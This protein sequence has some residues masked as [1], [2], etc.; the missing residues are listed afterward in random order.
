MK[1]AIFGASGKTGVRLVEEGLRRDWEIVGACRDL[2]ADKLSDFIREPRFTLRTAPLI[3]DEHF[4]TQTLKGCDAAVSIMLSV[5][6]LMCTDLVRSLE[7]ASQAN[8]VKRFIFTAGEVTARPDPDERFTLRQKIMHSVIPP[9]LFFLPFS[10]R[11]MLDA[12]VMIEHADWDWT[13]VRAPTLKNTP[14]TGYR[15]CDIS[16]VT[17]KHVLSREDYAACMLDSIQNRE[18]LRKKLTVVTDA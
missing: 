9:M 6:N 14:P 1:V 8:G 3:S 10:V 7:A 18:H 15:F 13:I 12:S 4:V 5:R 2:S 17:G 16:E 11:D